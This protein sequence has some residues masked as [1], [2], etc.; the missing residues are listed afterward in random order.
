M[1]V[2]TSADPL[3]RYV[4]FALVLEEEDIRSVPTAWILLKRVSKVVQSGGLV[5]VRRL[6]IG[7]L[8]LF[9][10]VIRPSLFYFSPLAV[11]VTR[12][13]N[14]KFDSTGNLEKAT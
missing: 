8:C 5:G 7:P 4:T 11:H 6:P 1:G 9:N 2:C 3:T 10:G 12:V 14:G 13:G